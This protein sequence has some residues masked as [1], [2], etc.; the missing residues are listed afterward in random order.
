MKFI[1]FYLQFINSL[2]GLGMFL[3]SAAL[4]RRLRRYTATGDFGKIEGFFRKKLYF[5]KNIN[6]EHF[7]ISY[8]FS[9][10]VRQTCYNL[11]QKIH[12]EKRERTSFIART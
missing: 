4:I 12:V 6:F 3:S 5:P 2:E 8:Y 1:V 11:I 9:Q 7:E 10:I